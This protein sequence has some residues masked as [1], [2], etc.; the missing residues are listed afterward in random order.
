M[1]LGWVIYNLAAFEWE[2]NDVEAARIH[3]AF[4]G[5]LALYHWQAN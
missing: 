3:V 4:R 2:I 1:A 5:M